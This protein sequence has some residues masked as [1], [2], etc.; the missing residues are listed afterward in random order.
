MATICVPSACLA[1]DKLLEDITIFC[2]TGARPPGVNMPS[3]LVASPLKLGRTYKS[4][5]FMSSL[6][7]AGNLDVVQLVMFIA[8]VR[9]SS[10]L[11]G[12]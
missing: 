7:K 1:L 4:L 6:C 8:G 2:R 3:L 5:L 9:S 10:I 12:S 11:D